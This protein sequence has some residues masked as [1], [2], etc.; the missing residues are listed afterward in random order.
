MSAIDMRSD[1]V[2]LPTPEMRR[3][4]AEAPLGDDVY[5]EDPTVVRLEEAAAGILGMEA[6]L[7][8]PSGTMGNLA[9]VLT[10]CGRGD[11]L[12]LGA[13][14]H[15]QNFEGGGV[16]ALGSAVPLLAD[17]SS[18]CIPP[19]EVRAHCRPSNVHFAPARLLCL[20]NT[21]NRMGGVIFPQ[22]Q[23]IDIC[24]AARSHGLAC[25]L[26]GARLWN[27]SAAT[28]LPVAELAAP[29]DLV[30]VSM[31][32]G[33]GAPA[34]S[35]LAGPRELIGAAVRH[36]RMLGGAMRQAGLL[37]A[38]ALY[39]LENHVE[40]LALDHALARRLADGLAGIEGL[41]V[42]APQTNIVFADLTGDA[43]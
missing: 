34:G 5:G 1:T 36:R 27:V 6:A 43:R 18:G 13:G 4:I 42:Q 20:E 15:M 31:S 2:T 22:A 17:D 21:H 10:H 39:A 30:M 35:L 26:D 23:V 3:A 29:F 14:S 37:A 41:Q 32:K 16:A 28:G 33:L 8:M 24:A 7:F 12:I 40:R 11:A 9:A 25:Y 38:A 19:E